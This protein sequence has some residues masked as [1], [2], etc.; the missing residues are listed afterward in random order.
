M[1]ASQRLRERLAT[2]ADLNAA[3]A[4]LGWDQETYMPEAAVQSRAQQLATLG[5]L[6]HEMLS[7]DETAVLLQQANAENAGADPDGD[8]ARLLRVT[9]RDYRL[10]TRLPGD[11]VAEMARTA[12][13]SQ[14]A[15]RQARERDEFAHFAPHLEHTLDL[16]LRKAEALGYVEHPY[17]ALLDEYEPDMRTAAVASTFRALRGELVELV[18]QIAESPPPD[19]SFLHRPYDGALQWDF[20]LE[21]IADFGFDF[22]RGRQ[23][24]S[25]HPF[26]TNFSIDDA[27]ITTRVQEDFLPS[28]LF[29]SLHETGHALYEM[30]IDPALERTPLASGTSYGMHESQS[31]LWENLVGRSAPFW[32]RYYRRLQQLFPAQLGDVS[33]AAFHRA[34]NKVQPSLIR[35]EA[36]EVTYN[37]HIMLRFEIET[38]LVRG[39]LSVAQLPEAWREGMRDLLGIVPETDADG[40]LQDIHWALGSIGYFPTYALGNLMSVQLFD[41]ARTALPDLDDQIGRGEFVPLRD[42][43]RQNI[44]RHGRKFTADELLR[45]VTGGGLDHRP[46]LRYARKKYGALYG[47]EPEGQ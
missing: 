37:L 29:G 30:G 40:V 16:A 12:A 15:W 38:Q 19:D 6:A 25:A 17:D 4:L 9:E 24:R 47:F 34:V 28:C 22:K 41:A 35:V 45:R 14:Q 10:A 23:D 43:L 21:V 8:I 42:W 18:R 27:R 20:G 33:L 5:R 36:D 32:R 7:A 13:L 26:S 2:I 11:L 39:E 3:A 46:W 44:H 1:S 31:R